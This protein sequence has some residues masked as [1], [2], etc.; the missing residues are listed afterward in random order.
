M[1]LAVKV[2]RLDMVDA[3][4]GNGEALVDYI[5]SKNGMSPLLY[6][7]SLNNVDIALFL[8]KEGASVALCDNRCVT[9]LMMA[10][11]TGNIDMLAVVAGE[12]TPTV[13]AQDENGWTAL[14]WAVYANSPGAVEYLLHELMADRHIRCIQKKKP[15]PKKEKPKKE[16][17]DVQ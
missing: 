4:V 11:G 7:I 16:K 12:Y 3:L 6:A 5:D 10:A 8:L 14:H 17:S 13:D 1:L 9:P 2:Q 15:E